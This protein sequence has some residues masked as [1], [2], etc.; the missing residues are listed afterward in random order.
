[1]SCISCIGL[2]FALLRS[3]GAYSVALAF[4]PEEP[5]KHLVVAQTLA[6]M[7][8]S[9]ETSRDMIQFRSLCGNQGCGEDEKIQVSCPTCDE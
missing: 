1:M 8:V 2:G 4:K 6:F 9:V 7:H 5:Y 3:V